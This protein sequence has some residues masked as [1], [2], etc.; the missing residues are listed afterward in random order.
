V[1]AQAYPGGFR[2]VV[3]DDESTDGTS[4]AALA[5]VSASRGLERLT[6]VDGEPTPA[7][8][9]GK[10]WAMAQGTAV[11]GEASYILF[12]DA[13]IAL[14]P[15][16]VAALARAAEAGGFDV[17]SQM[18]LLH[19]AS[20]W[21]RALIPAFVYF[22][23]QLYP[24]R[25]VSRCA[26]RTAAAA[27]GCM[28]VRR[29]ALERIGGLERIRGAVIDDVALATAMKRGSDHGCLWLGHGGP[30]VTSVREYPR[31]A[32][33]WAM[34]TRSASA[35][36]RH[37]WLLASATVAGLLLLYA[38]PPIAA[39]V[40]LVAAL[41]TASTAATLAAVGGF[42][43]WAIMAVTYAPT[44][45]MFRLRRLR[46]AMLPAVAIVYAAMTV[47]SVRRHRRGVGVAWKGRPSPRRLVK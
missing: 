37:S 5:A 44:L 39:V 30:D 15:G 24:F 23:T 31:L 6:V 42:V 28:L 41:R 12:M 38:G 26:A 40:G 33:I 11:A 18:A 34:V 8:W 19:V 22:F 16:V 27:G 4:A 35:Q 32:D 2:V 1:L 17:V 13:D 3:V 20:V 46:A 21:S 43:G 45:R 10:V 9:A 14:R 25:R 29:A 7:G 36:L 47:D